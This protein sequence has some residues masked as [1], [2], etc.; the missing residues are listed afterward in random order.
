MEGMVSSF[1]V[2]VVNKWHLYFNTDSPLNDDKITEIHLITCSTQK[3]LSALQAH[4]GID[5]QSLFGVP[6][7]LKYL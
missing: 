7:I 1:G 2:T 3:S 6:W 5:L 4:W